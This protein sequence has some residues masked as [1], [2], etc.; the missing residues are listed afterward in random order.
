MARLSDFDEDEVIEREKEQKNIVS[1]YL[2]LPCQDSL[3][4]FSKSSLIRRTAFKIIMFKHFE[5]LILILI[6]SS[7][8]KLVLDTYLNPNPVS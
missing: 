5:N 1:T 4:I 8:I 3:F 2:Q 6:I 7:S